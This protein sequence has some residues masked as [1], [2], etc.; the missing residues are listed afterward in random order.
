MQA[1]SVEQTTSLVAFG[2]LSVLLCNLCL[3]DQIRIHIRGVLKG[4]TLQSLLSF[5]QEFLDHFRRA[6]KLDSTQTEDGEHDVK[7]SFIDRFESVLGALRQGEE[8]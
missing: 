8:V 4:G 6:E 7:S 1:S 2:Y 3:N 5:V